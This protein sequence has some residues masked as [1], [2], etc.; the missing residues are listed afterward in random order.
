MGPFVHCCIPGFWNGMQRR[1]RRGEEGGGH[2]SVS[3]VG[4][5]YLNKDP[6]LPWLTDGKLLSFLFSTPSEATLMCHGEF[7]QHYQYWQDNK[8][9]N[10]VLRAQYSV[11]LVDLYQSVPQNSLWVSK[12]PDMLAVDT[13]RE[14]EMPLPH[15]GMVKHHKR[16]VSQLEI[17][18]CEPPRMERGHLHICC[19][20][21]T[22]W[23]VLQVNSHEVLFQLDW[24]SCG[25]FL[26]NM[27]PEPYW[28]SSASDKNFMCSL[29][30]LIG[31]FQQLLLQICA[32]P[33]MNKKIGKC[34]QSL[35]KPNV[36]YLGWLCAPNKNSMSKTCLSDLSII[37]QGPERN[38]TWGWAIRT[39]HGWPPS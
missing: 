36:P 38:R 21:Y 23:L 15:L 12:T 3:N 35:G 10:E 4:T 31:T 24:A 32:F 14:T 18:F 27:S 8:C 26:R 1:R 28:V 16:L 5:F 19:G 20:A 37:S 2:S 39:F 33:G 9:C 7:Y 25:N 17:C 11:K 13:Q 30:G 34:N 22:P 29:A 6:E